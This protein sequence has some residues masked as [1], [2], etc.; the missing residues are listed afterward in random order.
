MDAGDILAQEKI[1]ILPDEKMPELRKRLIKL[2][3]K[4][5]LKI[6]PEYIENNPI[7][8]HASSQRL[9]TSNGIKITT[10]DENKATY[11]KKIKKEDG[12]IDL[13]DNA[14]K[15]YNKFRAYIDWPRNFIF[16][17]DKRVIITKAKLES[18]KFVIDKIIPE[19]KKEVDYKN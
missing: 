1:N 14:I 5:L 18:D 9:P 2:G 3:G 6:L 11:C 13:N 16:K 7:R 8:S 15:N 12:L 19:G 10:Q 4:L 17:N